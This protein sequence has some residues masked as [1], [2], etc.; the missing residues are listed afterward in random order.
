M[1]HSKVLPT[2]TAMTPDGHSDEEESLVDAWISA[3]S[4]VLGADREVV[5]R[6]PSEAKGEHAPFANNLAKPGTAEQDSLLILTKE[7][8]QERPRPRPRAK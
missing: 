7:M 3:K 4:E 2:C 1:P 6:P 8:P 5:A